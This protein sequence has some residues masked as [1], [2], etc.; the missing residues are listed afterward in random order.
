VT[1]LA[2]FVHLKKKSSQ[3]IVLNYNALNLGK[4][5]LCPKNWLPY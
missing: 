5:V 1:L 4:E 2:I 3:I